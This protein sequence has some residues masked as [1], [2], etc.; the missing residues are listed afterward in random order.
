MVF[1]ILHWWQLLLGARPAVGAVDSGRCCGALRG[2]TETGLVAAAAVAAA[3]AAV[4]VDGAVA[5]S[6]ECPSG[7]VGRAG[8]MATYAAWVWRSDS[9]SDSARASALGR[10]CSAGVRRFR[11]RDFT[12]R[13]TV[14]GVGGA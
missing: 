13:V 6:F 3:A 5:A 8:C 10:R 7:V 11:C 12:D 4:G 14:T 2:R 9:S 1:I